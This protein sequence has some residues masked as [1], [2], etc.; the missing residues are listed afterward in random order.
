MDQLKI[1]IGFSGGGF[2]AA[3]FNLGV[4]SYLDCI[5]L[6]EQP[7]LQSVVALSTI[8]GGTITGTRYAVGVKRGETFDQIYNA[9]YSFL[10]KEDLVTLSLDRLLSNKGW[11]DKRVKSLINA[12][13]D[14]YDEHLF[15]KEKF[16]LLLKD[17]P[18]MHLKH[19]SFNATEFANALQFRFQVSEKILNPQPNEP[20]QGI[21]GNNY[22]RVS[23]ETASEI[24]MA[25]ILAASSCFPGGFE[26]INFPSDFI[27]KNTNV[28]V[29]ND[30]GVPAR[31]PVGLMDGGIVDNQGVEPLLLA[32]ERMKRNR[33][34]ENNKT[35][36]ENAV[37]LII[38]SDV[39][40]PYMEEYETSKQNKKWWK[41]VSPAELI[42]V[43]SVFLLYFIIHLCYS[44]THH[45]LLLTA[46]F[47]ALTTA[48]IIFFLV[49]RLI[50]SLPRKAH[51]PKAF[52]KPVGK[53][54]SLKLYVQENLVANRANSLLKLTMDVFLKHV[55]RLNYRRLY[56]D[57][58]WKNRRIMNAVYELRKGEKKLEEK[59]R[60]GEI[61]PE[62]IPS[63]A[64]QKVAEK[65]A[66]MGT[67]LWF[68][69]EELDGKM[70]DSL[71]A[72]GQFTMCWNLLEYIGK[73][74]KDASNTTPAHINLVGIEA[75][76]MQ[77]WK[78][79]NANPFWLIEKQNYTI[80]KKNT[81][82][83]TK[84]SV[85]GTEAN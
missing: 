12:F 42:V 37:D 4:L 9:I 16:G 22:Y 23:P 79:F 13:A 65:A 83:T 78:A 47:S 29:L 43:N 24:R 34:F 32:N 18:A 8:S 82:T 45:Q 66:S 5:S 55:R 35:S 74:K 14:I 30:N 15:N 51:V 36:T 26:P 38:V 20:T 67:T 68:T 60:K 46:V 70:L 31:L 7:F 52:V 69:K 54:L 40:S 50:A 39:A 77:H 11:N 85:Y 64:V 75:Q 3:G 73:I 33:N 27:L 49:G 59:I 2:R 48:S 10:S 57:S 80:V 61:K 81:K 44:Y 71:I 41:N 72:C 53:L 28:S 76:L 63:E 6:N 17:L 62:L 56:E 25:D 84:Q 21:I 1:A 19:V 58:G